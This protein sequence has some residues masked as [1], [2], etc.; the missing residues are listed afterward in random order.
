MAS[1]VYR[2]DGCFNSS[3]ST[4]SSEEELSHNK[5]PFE[6]YDASLVRIWHEKIASRISEVL[7]LE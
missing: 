4:I 7:M 1:K 6:D 2:N 5:C 3:H